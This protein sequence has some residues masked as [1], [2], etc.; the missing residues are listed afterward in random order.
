MKE[1]YSKDQN[2]TNDLSLQPGGSTVS[3]TYT[4]GT[5]IHYDKIKSV[6]KYVNAIKGKSD[7]VKIEVGDK[8]LYHV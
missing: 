4:N 2:R 7:V 1:I 8:V 5:V 3:V 6:S